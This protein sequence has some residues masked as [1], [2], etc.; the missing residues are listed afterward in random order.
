MIFPN[1]QPNSK[2][3]SIGHRRKQGRS[4]PAL[5]AAV[6]AAGTD[7]DVPVPAEPDNAEAPPGPINPADPV[8]AKPRPRADDNYRTSRCIDSLQMK[9]T[10]LESELKKLQG[11][12]YKVRI[13]CKAELRQKGKRAADTLEKAGKKQKVSG[14]FNSR[15][16]KHAAM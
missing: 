8:N 9:V 6:A 5:Q 11:A 3:I 7:G 12:I 1:G 15:S 4:N 13:D 10:K 2:G 16:F 14:K